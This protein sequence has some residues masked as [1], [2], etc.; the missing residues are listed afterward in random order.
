M[1]GR[2]FNP[3]LQRIPKIFALSERIPNELLKKPRIPEQTRTNQFYYLNIHRLSFAPR[4][5]GFSINIAEK[6]FLEI[7]VLHGGRT[8]TNQMTSNTKNSFNSGGGCRARV[9]L[10]SK[11]RKQRK[12][13]TVYPPVLEGVNFVILG[14]HVWKVVVHLESGM[15]FRSCV[16]STPYQTGWVLF[17]GAEQE[18]LLAWR[19]SLTR[20]PARGFRV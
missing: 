16:G 11:F 19:R 14:N 13:G 20:L 6:L 12:P 7:L 3:F 8:D 9:N 10:H 1:V 17:Q 5:H 18:A 4:K 2:S 15:T